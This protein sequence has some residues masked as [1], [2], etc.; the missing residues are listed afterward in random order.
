MHYNK[1]KTLLFI[2][3][4]ISYDL[5]LAVCIIEATPSFNGNIP[6]KDTLIK[7]TT[8]DTN[9]CVILKANSAC[10]RYDSGYEWK[11]YK[12]NYGLIDEFTGN[13]KQK[14][15]VETGEYVFNLNRIHEKTVRVTELS[16]KLI[17]FPEKNSTTNIVYPKDKI[18]LKIYDNQSLGNINYEFHATSNN[19]ECK[20]FTPT[21]DNDKLVMNVKELPSSVIEEKKSCKYEVSFT[22]TDANGLSIDS[23]SYP[24]IVREPLDG[25]AILIQGYNKTEMKSHKM[26][27]DFVKKSFQKAGFDDNNIYYFHHGE[28][29]EL[30][31]NLENINTTID[32]LTHDMEVN[33]ANIYIVMVG[34]S[35]KNGWF[36]INKTVDDREFITPTTVR[37]WLNKLE[38]NLDSKHKRIVVVG[39]CYS[40]NYID[41]PEYGKEGRIV[42][43]ST[44]DD[45]ISYKGFMQHNVDKDDATRFGSFFVA[46]LFRYL[47]AGYSMQDSF[48][49]AKKRTQIYTINGGYGLQTPLLAHKVRYLDELNMNKKETTIIDENSIINDFDFDES[50]SILS[51]ELDELK[52]EN[53]SNLGITVYIRGVNY[54]KNNSITTEYTQID[55]TPVFKHINIPCD[56]NNK[57]SKKIDAEKYFNQ[58]EKYEIFFIIKYDNAPYYAY[59]KRSFLHSSKLHDNEVPS[60]PKPLLPN[61]DTTSRTPIF[62]WKHSEDKD[63]DPINYTLSIYDINVD[64]DCKK[65]I[66]KVEGIESSPAVVNFLPKHGNYGWK[67]E[68]TD[69]YGGEV[70]NNDCYEF[71]INAVNDGGTCGN[72]PFDANSRITVYNKNISNLAEVPIPKGVFNIQAANT[73]LGWHQGILTTSNDYGG[74]WAYEGNAQLLQN[75]PNV[76]TDAL[77]NSQTNILEIIN[78]DTTDSCNLVM[79]YIPGTSPLIFY[80]I[81]W[82]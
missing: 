2:L 37:N 7:K 82:E 71:T 77:F 11:I 42:I 34:D 68:A 64:F 66:Y 3:F 35:N 19:F 5:V 12:V 25:Y 63:N 13:N 46:E 14:C 65:P 40:G 52:E 45:N 51:I 78:A 10:D 81:N 6:S 23:Q 1:L 48:N 30:F 36:T 33:P 76:S 4:L 73:D 22:A 28:D 50:N 44:T 21:F 26:T 47:E 41:I 16:A 62:H 54:N 24:M 49:T 17:D 29:S 43:T 38:N 56:E 79:Q 80:Y 58:Q 8:T 53:L 27:L 31:P 39:S 69:Y 18:K 9:F 61:G 59:A 67:I 70:S 15:F 75:E 72:T 32:T 20:K 60:A 55:V 74:R 57:C